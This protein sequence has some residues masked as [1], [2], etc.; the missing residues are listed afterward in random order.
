MVAYIYD[1]SKFPKYLIPNFTNPNWV[2]A[3]TPLLRRA[4]NYNMY[5][6]ASP[7]HILEY[8]KMRMKQR[9]QKGQNLFWT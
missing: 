6:T 7:I 9:Q 3:Q 8:A 4:D 5:S 2:R 1:R